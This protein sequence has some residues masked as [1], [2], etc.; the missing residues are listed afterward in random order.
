M[1]L[2]LCFKSLESREYLLCPGDVKKVAGSEFRLT[3]REAL[4]LED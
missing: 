4:A 3:L 2:C 1:I